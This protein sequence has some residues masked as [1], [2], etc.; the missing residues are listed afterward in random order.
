[1]NLPVIPKAP[2]PP[3]AIWQG[4]YP[5]FASVPARGAGFADPAWLDRLERGLAEARAGRG[6]PYL[7]TAFAAPLERL[8][9]IDIGGGFGDAHAGL[10]AAFGSRLALTA[11]V[12]EE[13]AVVAAAEARGLA[14]DGLGFAA[15]L[16]PAGDIDLVHLGSTLQ[17]LDDWQDAL[18][19]IAE[20]APRH[21]LLSDVFA[22]PGPDFVTGQMVYGSLIPFRFLNL[23]GLRR[24]LGALGWEIVLELPYAPSILGRRGPLPMELFP[25]DHR[26]DYPLHI[27]CR[28]REAP[29][30]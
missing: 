5:D 11:L 1:M 9:L 4:L 17:Y 13:P 24:V 14:G 21:L 30:S 27:L 25:A 2:P 20:L 16:P 12:V 8:S 18:A 15:E 26:L 29:P 7:L 28:A 23:E 6:K 10:R 22:G 3:E 19:R